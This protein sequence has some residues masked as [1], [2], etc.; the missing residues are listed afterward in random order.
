M[1]KMNNNKKC[2]L[3]TS[4][5]YIY[6]IFR[7]DWC[8]WKKKEKKITTLDRVSRSKG[9]RLII[10]RKVSISN[11]SFQQY[12][13]TPLWRSFAI[14]LKE[15]TRF[16]RLFRK[17]RLTFS[18]FLSRGGICNC[19]KQRR[20]K[21]ARR[22]CKEKR[23][24]EPSS[25]S[26]PDKNARLFQFGVI[27]T[28]HIGRRLIYLLRVRIKY[29]FVTTERTRLSNQ[30]GVNDRDQFVFCRF[31]AAIASEFLFLTLSVRCVL[32]V[33]TCSSCKTAILHPIYRKRLLETASEFYAKGKKLF[34]LNVHYYLY[35][36]KKYYSHNYNLTT[37]RIIT[38]KNCL[39]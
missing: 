35:R 21:R 39:R 22:F 36:A 30:G 16:P 28:K 29:G 34:I 8:N 27:A 38:L 10:L 9:E 33:C 26:P 2:T 37:F 20:L 31:P 19:R 5:K 7:R 15:K 24:R 17:W 6:R 13:V 25:E 11:R 14:I 32:Y 12:T 4:N 23:S 3:F 18:Q 1:K